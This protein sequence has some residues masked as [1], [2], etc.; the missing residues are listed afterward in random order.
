MDVRVHSHMKYS[1]KLKR[2]YNFN[3]RVTY[4]E[5]GQ[6]ELEVVKASWVVKQQAEMQDFVRKIKA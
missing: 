6:V 2:S 5:L 3:H 1:I 4:R